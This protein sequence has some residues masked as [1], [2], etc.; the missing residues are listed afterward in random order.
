M[1]TFASGTLN[2]RSVYRIFPYAGTDCT[3][4]SYVQQWA[5]EQE[6]TGLEFLEEVLVA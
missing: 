3:I 6:L 4:V 5:L 1:R 2:W